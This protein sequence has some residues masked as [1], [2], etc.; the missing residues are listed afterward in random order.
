M[1]HVYLSLGSN[2]G[3]RAETI[4]QAVQLL[5]LKE[6]R[7]SR[8]YEA[9][10]W[11]TQPDQ[12]WFLNCA[13]SGKTELSVHDF[14]TGLLKTEVYLGR[15]REAQERYAP[16]TIDLDLL[17]YDDLALTEDTLT[18]PHP[19][20]VD[21]RF[22]LAPLNEIAPDFVHPVL[23]KKVKLLLKD[24]P[25]ALIVRPLQDP[26]LTYDLSLL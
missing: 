2:L 23:K 22:V 19:H 17:F 15:T 11:G 1:A 20:I 7:V 18:V 10:P 4:S 6:L 13:V 21:R 24:C 16:R 12:P 3:D 14:F 5:N 8:L 25:D 9:E 26:I